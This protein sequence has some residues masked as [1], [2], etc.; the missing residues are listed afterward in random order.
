M[1]PLNRLQGTEINWAMW[2][3]FWLWFRR[4]DL[5][6]IQYLQLLFSVIYITQNSLTQDT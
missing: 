1:S 6:K 4:W 5:W 2:F 3:N